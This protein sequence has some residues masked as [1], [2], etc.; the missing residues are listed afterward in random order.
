MTFRRLYTRIILMVVAMAGMYIAIAVGETVFFIFGKAQFDIDGR[1][2]VSLPSGWVLSE[3]L[4]LND[5]LL[6][7]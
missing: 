1:G 7:N 3:Y 2:L 6:A 5:R 4:K